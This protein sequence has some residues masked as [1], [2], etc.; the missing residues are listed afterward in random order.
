M[1]QRLEVRE[2]DRDYVEFWPAGARAKGEF[3]CSD[4]GYGVVVTVTLPTCPMCA[5]ESWE[6][7]PWSPF[8]RAAA[9]ILSA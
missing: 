1:V 9:T 4:C 3:R 2:A 5:C 8:R 6:Q 7:A